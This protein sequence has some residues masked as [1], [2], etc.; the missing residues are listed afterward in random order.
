M[1][2]R[3]LRKPRTARRFITIALSLCLI[4]ASATARAANTCPWMNEA[5]ASGLLGGDAV[6]VY[7]AV[8][9]QP[10]I[11]TFTQQ[12]QGAARKLVVTVEIAQDPHARMATIVQTCGA[13]AATLNAIGN[14]AMTCDPVERKGEMAERVVG[15]VRDQ[16]FT[17]T[18][19]S[20]LKNDPI[21]TRDTL[22]T[23]SQTAAEQIS[24]NLF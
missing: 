13:N 23:R 18:L 5:T 22:K 16:V 3:Q 8:P 19:L 17:I 1:G 11:C 10:S 4:G 12:S 6:G 21:L 7:T 14:E 2:N 24:G 20:S 9:G 15:R